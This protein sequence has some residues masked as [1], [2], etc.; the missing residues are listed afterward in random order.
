MSAPRFH[1]QDTRIQPA[2][3]LFHCIFPGSL[4]GWRAED[5]VENTPQQTRLVVVKP[6][7][8]RSVH[9]ELTGIFVEYPVHRSRIAG[10]RLGQCDVDQTALVRIGRVAK[11]P[12][13]DL[14]SVD[15][16]RASRRDQA[17]HRGAALDRR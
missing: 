14:Q 6:D 11:P 3:R 12:P 8:R 17:R 1:R 10:P 2:D 15:A 4:V 7:C 9:H 5:L 13:R 16:M